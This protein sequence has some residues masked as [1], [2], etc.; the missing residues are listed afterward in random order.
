MP[1]REN[2]ECGVE[3]AIMNRATSRTGPFSHS[4]SCS[5]LRTADGQAPA[6]RTGPGCVVF[7]DF[8]YLNA[9]LLT[10]VPQ[11]CLEN[12]PTGIPRR[13]R[14]S[15]FAYGG[16]GDIPYVDRR[17]TIHDLPGELV[18]DVP[19]LPLDLSVESG[20][21]FPLLC[22]LGNADL[23]LYPT[24]PP[25]VLKPAA[26]G[27]DCD[28]LEPQIDPNRIPAGVRSRPRKYLGTK[29]PVPAGVLCEAARSENVLGESVRVPDV[30][31]VA[32]ETDTATAPLG[33]SGL[34]WNPAEASAFAVGL[35]PAEPRSF[36][37]PTLDGV[38]LRKPLGS[39]QN[40]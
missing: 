3:I 27:A 39:W 11:H 33:S 10:F 24:V 2:V 17:R 20:S 6:A 37:R 12:A 31:V 30:E 8:P 4:E 22:S 23:L 15:G 7:R 29:V 26:V 25:G 19:A 14:Q 9:G 28:L 32:C 16:G 36:G 35:S 21:P 13:L 1:D 38:M 5:T 18:Q 40:L 34:E